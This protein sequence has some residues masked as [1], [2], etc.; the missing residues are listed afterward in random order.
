MA[1]I[2]ASCHVCILP[3]QSNKQ[4]VWLQEFPNLSQAGQEL[5]NGLL[6]YDPTRRMTA[7]QALKHPY[8]QQLPLPLQP[9]ELPT[10]PSAHLAMPSSAQ[11]ARQATALRR[12]RSSRMLCSLGMSL[13]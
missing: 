8:F 12:Y 10:F 11:A 9:D 5:L 2:P 1:C 3:G 13:L 7:R 6:T 4:Q